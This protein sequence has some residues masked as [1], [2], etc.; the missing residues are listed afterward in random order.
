MHR[1]DIRLCTTLKYILQP[2]LGCFKK[3]NKKDVNKIPP[4]H[5]YCKAY[6]TV[7]FFGGPTVFQKFRVHSVLVREPRKYSNFAKLLQFF[8][9]IQFLT[10]S[11][12]TICMKSIFFICVE[13]YIM[14][15]INLFL[16][17]SKNI[18]CPKSIYF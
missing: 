6:S 18:L 13:K 15:K 7:N 12:I 17:T 3:R 4:S 14:H 2:A 10:E 8:H 5:S 1:V 16:F 11:K 9:V